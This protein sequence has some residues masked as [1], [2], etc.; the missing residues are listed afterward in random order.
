MFVLLGGYIVVYMGLLLFIV[1][2]DGL[3]VVIGYEMG[4]V[5]VWYGFECMF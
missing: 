1:N 4:Y 3:V 5:I 2:E